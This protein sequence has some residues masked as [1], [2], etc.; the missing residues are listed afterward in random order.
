MCQLL[1]MNCNVPTDVTFS[2]TGFAQR[3]GKA[4]HP[5]TDGWGIA[6]L[7]T[8]GFS[9]S[10]DHLAA[11]DSPVAELI[12]VTHRAEG[13]TTTPTSGQA[14]QG[15]VA[16][17]TATRSCGSCRALLG[18]C[19][20]RGPER[21][22]S[23]PAFAF[24]APSDEPIANMRFAGSSK[25]WPNHTPACPPFPELTPNAQGTRR[26]HSAP[27]HVQLPACQ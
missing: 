14:T 22:P 17:R 5:H 7:R 12:A 9:H 10:L 4:D 27:R 23:S 1:G 21:F 6:F 8:R 26:A 15:V 25:S 11:V 2:F 13:T 18:L 3:G 16:C 19:P 24:P 20:Q